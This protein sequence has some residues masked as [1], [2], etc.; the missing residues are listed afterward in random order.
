MGLGRDFDWDRNQSLGVPPL[1][2]HGR[3]F[4]GFDWRGDVEAEDAVDTKAI[5]RQR[6][7]QPEQHD[8]VPALRRSPH[9]AMM[10]RPRLQD[11]LMRAAPIIRLSSGEH[12]AEAL[13]GDLPSIDVVELGA[14]KTEPRLFEAISDVDQANMGKKLGDTLR[15]DIRACRHLP[16]ACGSKPIIE[17]H[18]LSVNNQLCPEGAPG[19]HWLPPRRK[20]FKTPANRRYLKRDYVGFGF[21]AQAS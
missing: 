11:P 1:R 9:H 17:K 5:L 19:L 2:W 14:S 12:L 20:S 8:M 3:R 4:D 13:A 21:A 10:W 7:S 18:T 15:I 16:A 6:Q